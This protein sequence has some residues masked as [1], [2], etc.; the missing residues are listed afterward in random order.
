MLRWLTKSGRIPPRS[1]LGQIGF[2]FEIVSTGGSPARFKV[3]R[4]SI[5]AVR[6]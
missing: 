3:D 1:T 6:R 2:G 4:F 5:R